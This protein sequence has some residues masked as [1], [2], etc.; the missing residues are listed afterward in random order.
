MTEFAELLLLTAPNTTNL[1]VCV[2]YLCSGDDSDSS[3]DLGLGGDLFR[4]SKYFL[5]SLCTGGVA[6]AFL[7]HLKLNK[8]TAEF[9]VLTR[10]SYLLKYLNS[11]FGLQTGAK[12]PFFL[13]FFLIFVLKKVPRQ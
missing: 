9:K 1:T 4:G 7:W 10:F 12:L 5:G 8:N 11:V 3:Y 13:A 2:C 6:L